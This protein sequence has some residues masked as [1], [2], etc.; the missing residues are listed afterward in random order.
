MWCVQSLALQRRA[1][2]PRSRVSCPRRVAGSE[3]AALALNREAA[4]TAHNRVSLS[5]Y[6]RVHLALGVTGSDDG[7]A[8]MSC[9]GRTCVLAGWVVRSPPGH[10]R[11]SHFSMTGENRDAAE[12]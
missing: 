12:T 10:E 5:S 7:C 3:G 8:W 9:A 6:T 1:E 11:G 2:N 4:T